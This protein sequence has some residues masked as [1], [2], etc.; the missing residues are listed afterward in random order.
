MITY[1]IKKPGQRYNDISKSI[2]EYST[3]CHPVNNVWFIV[4]D[5][6]PSA[7]VN[8]LR[9]HADANDKLL[10][11]RVTSPGFTYNISA[12]VMDWLNRYI[13]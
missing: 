4:T 1:D 6:Q 2:K 10:V 11:L 7:V 12:E 5:E 3:W 8:K 9:A 13:Q